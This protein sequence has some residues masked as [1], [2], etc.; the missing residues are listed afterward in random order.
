MPQ[1]PVTPYATGRT[2]HYGAVRET[3]ADGGCGI[4]QHPCH[5]WG[6][7]IVGPTGTVVKAPTNGWVL[8]SQETDSPPFSGY[9]PAVVLF[10]HD[11]RVDPSTSDFERDRM[12]KSGNPD[13]MRRAAITMEYSLL[14]HL[15]PDTLRYNLPFQQARG[16]WDVK[17]QSDKYFYPSSGNIVRYQSWPS[18][19][20]YVKEGEWVGLIGPFKHVHWE[21]REGP[22]ELGPDGTR[23]PR[24]WLTL[25]DPSK[26]WEQAPASPMS[27]RE[28]RK[29]G[30]GL[31]T[32]IVI[33]GVLYAISE[34]G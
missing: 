5:H 29:S 30:G 12:V 6:A 31:G 17:K 7:D 11:D 34:H 4:G 26:T 20:Q 18:W 10:A 24:A 19:A 25:A 3:P 27:T 32:L 9:G 22:L 13:E 23:D 2:G 33:A 8:V 16:L 21:V 14:A 1:P 28:T 15:D